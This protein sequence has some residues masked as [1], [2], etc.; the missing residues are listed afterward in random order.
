MH[1]LLG[2][3]ELHRSVGTSL[4]HLAF[5]VIFLFCCCGQDALIAE[6]IPLKDAHNDKVRDLR[7]QIKVLD[8]ELANSQT[9]AAAW[10]ATQRQA[11]TLISATNP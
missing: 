5:C 11:N 3:S 7:A 2:C 8:A 9:G 1:V 4:I 6:R 10:A